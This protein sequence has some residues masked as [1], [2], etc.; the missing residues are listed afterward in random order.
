MAYYVGATLY[1]YILPII[2]MQ[3]QP[4]ADKTIG[5]TAALTA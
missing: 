1:M 5:T 2:K 3:M 4:S